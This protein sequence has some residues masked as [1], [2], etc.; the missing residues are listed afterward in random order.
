MQLTW[1]LVTY[2]MLAAGWLALPGYAAGESSGVAAPTNFAP[3]VKLTLVR[4]P[5]PSAGD[6]WEKFEA[7]F[8]ISK[9]EP[10]FV[11]GT[12]QSAKYRLDHSTFAIHAFVNSVSAAL[13]FDYNVRDLV[14]GSTP[15]KSDRGTSGSILFDTM[16]GARLKSDIDLTLGSRQFIGVKLVLPLGD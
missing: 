12:L 1:I 7:E 11:K 14:T 5:S 16:S 8:G 9:P 13:K 3:V 6:A 4:K 10:S 2:G 15:G